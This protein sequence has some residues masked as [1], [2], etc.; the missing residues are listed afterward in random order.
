MARLHD[1]PPPQGRQLFRGLPFSSL[2]V[3]SSFSL[4]ISSSLS[5]PPTTV[6]SSL[7]YPHSWSGSRVSETT[8]GERPRLCCLHTHLPQHRDGGERH[9]GRQG[10]C[11]CRGPQ[12]HTGYLIYKHN[13]LLL[14]CI[15][16]SWDFSYAYY[17]QCLSCFCWMIQNLKMCVC[18]YVSVPWLES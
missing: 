6:G 17:R 13:S 12:L 8:E 1:C 2:S 3:S 16:V 14:Q 18:L 15:L 9:E 4:P 7:Q 11:W 10:H 5:L